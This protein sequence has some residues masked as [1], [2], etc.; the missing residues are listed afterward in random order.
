MQEGMLE[1]HLASCNL[2]HLVREMIQDYQTAHQGPDFLPKRKSTSG[3]AFTAHLA[4]MYK[5]AQE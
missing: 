5:I 4:S 1:L 2:L 3:N